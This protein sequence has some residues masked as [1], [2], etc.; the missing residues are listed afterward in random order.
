[1]EAGIPSGYSCR[2]PLAADAFNMGAARNAKIAHGT[3]ADCNRFIPVY[4]RKAVVLTLAGVLLLVFAVPSITLPRIV[5]Q[6]DQQPWIAS[7]IV[8]VV[9]RSLDLPYKF[10]QFHPS[11]MHPVLEYEQLASVVLIC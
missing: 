9:A 5:L 10:S 1:M 7:S 4:M 2:S 11:E 6:P 3:T 8:P